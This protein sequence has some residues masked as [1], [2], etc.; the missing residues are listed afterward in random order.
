MRVEK[1]ST[2]TAWEFYS[3]VQHYLLEPWEK[4][5]EELNR[6]KKP[7]RGRQKARDRPIKELDFGEDFA[8]VS[9][10]SKDHFSKKN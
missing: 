7:S 9:P 1:Q 3:L 4:V 6:K 2:Q 10:I 5:L 8:I